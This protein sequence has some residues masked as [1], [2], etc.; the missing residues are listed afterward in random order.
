[1]G[2]A[3]DVS[4]SSIGVDTDGK[5]K[6]SESGGAVTELAKVNSSITGNA[7]TATNIAGSPTA[8]QY[9]GTNGA[10]VKGFYNLP[11][12]SSCHYNAIPGCV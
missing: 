10:S 12:S 1:M 9:Y 8:S 3:P 2:T 4:H 7:A 5:F 11:G 6:V